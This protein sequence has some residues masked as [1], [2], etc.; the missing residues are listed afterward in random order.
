MY[1]PMPVLTVKQSAHFRQLIVQR[2]ID[3]CWGWTGTILKDGRAQFSVNYHKYTAPRVAYWLHTHQDPGALCVCHSCD[4]PLCC[5]PKHLW[6]GTNVQNTIDRCQKNRNAHQKGEIHG[7]HKLT[8]EEVLLIRQATGTQKEI[9]QRFGI[10]QSAVSLITNLRRW[11][12]LVWSVCA[13][14]L[15]VS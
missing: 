4:N 6:L 2:S 12:H 10:S 1:R 14:R 3:A 11:R 15:P 7:G 13:A 5:N 9:A 8:E